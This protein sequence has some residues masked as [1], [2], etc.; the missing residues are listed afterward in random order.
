MFQKFLNY[1]N[2]KY[3]R[4]KN[5]KFYQKLNQ[6]K[7][8][9]Y[10]RDSDFSDN[11][12]SRKNKFKMFSL[13]RKYLNF[14]RINNNKYT[15]YYYYTAIALIILSIYIFLFSS[16]FSVQKIYIE[17]TDDLT[18]INLAYKAVEDLY[19]DSLFLMDENDVMAKIQSYQKNLKTINIRK[20]F[21]D[22]LKIDITSYKGAFNTKLFDRDYIVTNN[23]ILVPIKNDS[24]LK[25]IN[26]HFKDKDTLGIVDY[27][28]ILNGDDIVTANKIIT[29]I[30]NSIF[31]LKIENI[32]FF[33]I[34][35]EIHINSDL[36]TKFI[37]DLAGNVDEQIA[38]TSS[39]FEKYRDLYKSGLNYIDLRIPEKIFYCSNSVK[40]T[41]EKNLKRIYLY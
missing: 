8:R 29:K 9:M 17:R 21:P 26:I 24:K 14:I 36:K 27:K 11:F 6:E 19:G 18:N 20:M 34:E 39:F 7:S 1:I 32:D 12:C 41:C 25:Y 5:R 13:T 10:L 40:N 31:D 4:L 2:K 16:Y 15:P 33:P 35:K 3:K 23:G 22:S 37:Y 38:K 28:D 30:N